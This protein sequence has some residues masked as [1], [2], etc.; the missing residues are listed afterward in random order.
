MSN[1]GNPVSIKLTQMKKGLNVRLF[2]H[3]AHFP[4]HK[5]FFFLLF[6]LSFTPRKRLKYLK[7]FT[8]LCT[9]KKKKK[10]GLSFCLCWTFPRSP[11]KNRSEYIWKRERK[12]MQKEVKKTEDTKKFDFHISHFTLF[13]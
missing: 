12:K 2:L 8:G 6:V 1:Q 4:N 9:P 5:N 11:K 13:D 7:K 3:R 10:K